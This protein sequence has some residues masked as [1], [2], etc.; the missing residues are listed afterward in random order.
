MHTT[1]KLST[2]YFRRIHRPSRHLI[3]HISID[4]KM[5]TCSDKKLNT[6]K[7]F[8]RKLIAQHTRPCNNKKIRH[9]R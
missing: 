9:M 5:R 4:L 6:Y 2:Y 8:L 7:M 1:R 3:F